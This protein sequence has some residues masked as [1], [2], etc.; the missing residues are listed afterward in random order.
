MTNKKQF[1]VII[2]GGSYAGLA[3]AMALGRALRNVLII[4]DGK[5]CNR[6]TPYSHN[7]LTQDGSTPK[8]I[9]TLA[10][11]QVLAYNTITFFEGLVVKGVKTESGFEVQTELGREFASTKIVFATGIKDIMPEIVGFSECWGI[12]ILHCPYCHG[13]EVK[14]EITGILGNSEFGFEFSKLISNWTKDLTLFTNGKPTLSDDQKAGLKKNSIEILEKEIKEF[15]HL[16]GRLENIIF[17]DGSKQ[18][19][20]A[21][22]TRLA[23]KQTCTVAEQLGCDLT[24][25]GYIKV[26]AFQKTTATDVFACGDNTTRMRAVANAVAAGTLTGMTINKELVDLHF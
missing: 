9:S 23:F 5:P 8:E 21:M 6:Q 2:I 16:N 15:E 20:K 24:E 14:N 17:K 1:D 7:F 18:T 11:Q 13:F 25:D 22:Y 4:D 19:V 26:D 12:S 10:K 3:T